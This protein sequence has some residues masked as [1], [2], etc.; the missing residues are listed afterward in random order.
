MTHPD[1]YYAR[2]E[3]WSAQVD[4]ARDA[5]DIDYA[6]VIHSASFR[7]LQGKTQILNLGDSDFYRT[8]LT[9]SLEVAQIAGS[10]IKSLAK[11]FPDH[12]ATAYL[13]DRSLMQAIGLTHDLGHPPFG[14][15]GEVA[16]NYCLRGHGGFEGN[17]QTL[18]ILSRLETFSKSAGANLTRRTL[19]G[20]LKYPASFRAVANPDL[21]PS[22]AIGPTTLEIIDCKASKPPKCYLD[23]EAEIVDWVLEPLPATERDAFQAVEAALGKHGKTRHK[24]FDCSLM[25][26]ADD[27][28]YGVHDL[29]DAIAL[30]L[31]TEAGFR[32]AV[33]EADCTS[34]LDALKAKYPQESENDVYEK[35]VKALFSGSDSRKHYVNRLVHHF[36]TAVEII[37]TSFGEPLLR[38]R[39]AMQ[40]GP[41]RFLEALKAFVFDD[42]IRSPGVQHLEFKGQKL[43][44]AVFEALQS[45]PKRLLPRDQFTRFDAATDGM[46][47]IG[48]YVSGMTDGYLL[49]TYDRLFSPR[50][51]SVFD[52]L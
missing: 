4:D 40:A 28:A 36:L 30:G 10:L 23:S 18:R 52:K 5:G 32:T 22:L 39:A 45:D 43:V 34:F 3:S 24:S 44:V 27:I 21:T 47:V 51:G 14:H 12:P 37:E 46:R 1:W 35:M 17:G 15:G 7:R 38:Y 20:V 16:L 41:Q 42:V 25:D 11:R 2:R 49:K 29:E 9:H 19:L 13:P 33:P 6:R 48:D 26:V 50:M 31:V 8:R